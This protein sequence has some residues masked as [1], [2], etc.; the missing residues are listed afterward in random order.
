MATR[1]PWHPDKVVLEIPLLARAAQEVETRLPILMGL[2][3][4]AFNNLAFNH[5]VLESAYAAWLP[6]PTTSLGFVGAGP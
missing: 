1:E 6:W 2:R 3:E 5:T 4:C